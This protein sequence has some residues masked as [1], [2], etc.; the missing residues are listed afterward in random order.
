MASPAGSRGSMRGIS[1]SSQILSEALA[2]R[3]LGDDPRI[4][5]LQEVVGAARLRPDAGQPVATEG[6]T[7]DDGA[8]DRTVDVDVAGPQA[9][10]RAEHV[11]RRAG[12]DARGERVVGGT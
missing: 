9:L 12:E 10:G 8:G 3:V 7:A 2:H 4:H 5:E 6:L 1:G 11:A